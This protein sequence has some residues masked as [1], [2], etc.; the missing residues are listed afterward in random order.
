MTE[1]TNQANTTA[2][3]PIVTTKRSQWHMPQTCPKCGEAMDVCSEYQ[4][5]CDACACIEIEIENRRR[6]VYA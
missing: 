6:Q 1:K 2:P 4:T 3:R 5:V